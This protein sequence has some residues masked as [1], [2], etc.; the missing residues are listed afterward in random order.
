MTPRSVRR[1]PPPRDDPRCVCGHPLQRYWPNC[2][3]CS[4]AQLW[5][6]TGGVAGAECPRCRWSIS[7]KFSFCPWCTLDLADEG[8]FSEEPLKAPRGFRMDARCDW[9]C[10]GGVQYPMPYCPWC[11]KEQSWNEDDRFEGDCPR[12]A[13]GVDDWMATCPWCGEDATGQDLIPKALRQVRRLLNVARISDWGYRVLLRPGVSGVDPRYPKVVEIEQRYVVGARRR[14]EIPWPMLVGL[15]SHELGHSFLYHHWHWTRSAA[16]RR[17]FGEVAKAYRVLDETW[18]DFQ[19]RRVANRPVNHVSVYAARHPQED[20]AETF[21]F[22]LTRRGRL[23]E[24]F[25]EFGRKRKG[26]IVYEKFLVLHDYVRSLRGS[27]K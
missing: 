13:R 15:I 18:V 2:P 12:C 23:R 20:F 10:G 1:V 19:R 27:R 14:D 26:V 11:G 16:F 9:R 3:N 24:L 25:T 5:R 6:D 22:Y 21:R 17:T 8:T 7:P 4:R